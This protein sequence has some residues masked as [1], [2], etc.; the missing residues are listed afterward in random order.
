MYLQYF[1][2]VLFL[3]IIEFGVC[4][5]ITLW[6]QCLGLNLDE[7]IMVKVLQGSYGVPGK[8]QLT[9]AMDLAQTHFDCC[10]I[11]SDINYDTSLWRL[12]GYGPKELTVP[13]S[14]CRLRNRNEFG[15]Y[16]DPKPING[17]M[18]QSLQK[19]VNEKARNTEVKAIFFFFY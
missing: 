13:I 14:C 12:Q 1:L 18:C 9:A 3:L 4:L 15:A 5:L 16:L 6:P 8:E 19:D 2:I 11:D 17:T 10:A 7:S